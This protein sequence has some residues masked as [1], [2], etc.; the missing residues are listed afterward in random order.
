MLCVCGRRQ[1]LAPLWACKMKWCLHAPPYTYTKKN[2]KN[3]YNHIQYVVKCAVWTPTLHVYFI[4]MALQSLYYFKIMHHHIE[5]MRGHFG[6]F[7]W[8]ILC[9]SCFFCAFFS[10][11]WV[12]LTLK[13]Q[14]WYTS[15]RIKQYLTFLTQF[16][17]SR[18]AEILIV[19]L[20]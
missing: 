16:R 20:N 1:L 14:I 12:G 11:K 17:L 10:F 2:W 19:K 8:K 9:L 18:L 4:N 13:K 5:V 3:C 15:V 7:T 6:C